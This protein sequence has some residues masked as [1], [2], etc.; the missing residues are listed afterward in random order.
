MIISE[1]LRLYNST[2][3]PAHIKGGEALNTLDAS[4]SPE[5]LLI[6]ESNLDIQTGDPTSCTA[7]IQELFYVFT[8]K[9]LL[10]SQIMAN[11]KEINLIHDEHLILDK[12]SNLFIVFDISVHRFSVVKQGVS[13][14]L[15][16]SNQDDFTYY[17][18]KVGVKF[19]LTQW[20]ISF[21]TSS[22]ISSLPGHDSMTFDDFSFFCNELAKH[23]QLSYSTI[24]GIPFKGRNTTYSVFEIKDLCACETVSTSS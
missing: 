22:P 17:C 4:F 8:S 14:T 9:I 10:F 15:V 23:D 24:F 19:T 16:H 3:I 18:G 5:S 11:A 6:T 1:I 2:T 13:F 20:L 12:H 7:S 21:K